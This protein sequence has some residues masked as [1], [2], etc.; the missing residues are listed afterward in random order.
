M[1]KN[2]LKPVLF[3]GIFMASV[4]WIQAADRVPSSQG[5]AVT[6]EQ[7]GLAIAREADR[8]NAGFGGQVANMEMQL[9]NAQGDQVQRQ[10]MLKGKE[11]RGGGE[12]SLIGFQWPADVK[13]TR[14][15]TWSHKD[16]DDDQWLFLPSIRSVKRISST[17]KSASFMGSEFSYEDLVNP[18]VEKFNY[19]YL[20]DDAVAGRKVWVMERAPRGSSSGYSREVVWMDQEYFNSLRIEY[21][22]RKGE[23]LKTAEMAGYRKI[24]NWWRASRV[25][26]TNRQTQKKSVLT[27]KTHKLRVALN[28]AE[29]ESQNLDQ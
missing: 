10:M 19:K 6:P 22:D 9:F 21:F 25:T 16:S 4:G 20:R 8:K 12:R 28:D 17:G 26:M 5:A 14:M 15:L 3:T 2:T 18:V 13:N 1:G 11:S 29:F 24:G 23:L 7:R 27:W